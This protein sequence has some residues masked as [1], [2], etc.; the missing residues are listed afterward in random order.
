MAW[1]FP[2]KKEGPLEVINTEDTNQSFLSTVEEMT[3]QVNEQNIAA[4][5]FSD[6]SKYAKTVAYRHAK[7][8][9]LVDGYEVGDSSWPTPPTYSMY[10]D[11]LGPANKTALLTRSSTWNSIY[12]IDGTTGNLEYTFTST[13]GL[14]F[15][16]A[17]LWGG[18]YALKYDPS[19]NSTIVKYRYNPIL[20]GLKLNGAFIPESI[21]G[22]ISIT[23]YQNPI[24][25]GNRE[26]FSVNID[27]VIPVTPGKNTVEV[28]AMVRS[29]DAQQKYMIPMVGSRAL[30]L[31]E[32]SN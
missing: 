8:E 26:V 29:L 5:G 18:Q 2:D 9:V 30:I 16:T 17:R 27:L 20:F 3:G 6:T 28:V 32:I 1:K 7:V 19:L 25:T 22:N 23:N 14:L 15:I 10:D 11:G 24:D 12:S 13:G 31:W 21:D 4:A